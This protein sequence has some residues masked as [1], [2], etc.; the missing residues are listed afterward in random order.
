[1]KKIV[2]LTLVGCLTIFAGLFSYAPS[3][4][5]AVPA[6]YTLYV[7]G[8]ISSSKLPTIVEKGT[9]LI[10]MKAVLTDL[11]Y[12]TTVDSKSK[13][14]T[15]KN[16]AGSYIIVTTGSKK[17]K[18]N[19]SAVLLSVPAKALNGTTYI[20]LSAVKQ[21]TGKAIGADASM[22]IAWIGEKPASTAFI[23][24]WGITTDQMKSVSGE[25]S[26]LDEGGTGDIYLLLY[27]ESPE[28][29][30]ELYIFYKDQL[31]ASAYFP[32]ISDQNEA[33][34]LGVYSGMFHST[35]RDYGK[36]VA[37]SFVIDKDIDAV[38]LD[39]YLK[40]LANEGS[41]SS[42]WKMGDTKIIILLKPTDSGYALSMKYVNAS[43]ESKVKVALDT[44]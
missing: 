33:Y 5:A 19:G 22:G 37:G 12:T 9:T 1:M 14:I 10:P 26:L 6:S 30:E 41:L 3:A 38:K 4:S 24:P 13:A 15:A 35:L 20:P 42:T 16:S 21:L 11:K 36:P 28:D 25:K 34:I 44:I 31:A 23:P 29:F 39:Q 7:D 40:L 32:D 8:N 43:V 18:I 2:Y 17:A 27:Q